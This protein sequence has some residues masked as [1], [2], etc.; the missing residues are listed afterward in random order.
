MSHLLPVFQIF[1]LDGKSLYTV[2]STAGQGADQKVNA[3][4]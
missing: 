2:F 3:E 1:I 4:D